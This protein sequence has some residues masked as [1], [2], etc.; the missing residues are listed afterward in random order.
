MLE[1]ILIQEEELDVF[2]RRPDSET[3]RFYVPIHP[4]LL[5]KDIVLDETL[6]QKVFPKAIKEW[7]RRLQKVLPVLIGEEKEKA[8]RYLEAKQKWRKTGSC[9]IRVEHIPGYEVSWYWTEDTGLANA[10][11][12][13]RDSGGSLYF[14]SQT[15]PEYVTLVS[16][17]AVNF[18]AEK[19]ALYRA[20]GDDEHPQIYCYKLHNVDSYLG[21]L[22]LLSW[23]RQYINAALTHLSRASP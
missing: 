22:F 1:D 16:P 13:G 12:I 2:R 8:E 11:S 23:G 18:S 20:E 15:L 10:L 21:A 4:S 17:H 7:K 19:I 9:T 14:N 6:P 3:F 5:R